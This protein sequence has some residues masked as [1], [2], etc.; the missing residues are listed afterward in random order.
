M[1]EPKRRKFRVYTNKNMD[2]IPQIQRLSESER[3]A[4]QAVSAVLPFRVNDYVIEELINW[5]NIPDDPIFQLTFPQP[6]MLAAEDFSRMTELVG[7]GAA[8]DKIEAAARTIQRR[9]NPHPAGQKELNVPHLGEQAVPGVQHKYRETVLFFP[10]AGQTCHAFCTY[11]FRWAQFVGL[12]DLKFASKESDV[13]VKYL[14]AHP[15]V[16]SVLITGGDPLVMKTKVL[17]RYIEPLLDPKL[18]HIESIRIG[19]KALAYWPF[20]FTTD[21]D[22]DDLMRLFEEIRAAGKHLALMAHYSHPREAETSA[23]QAAIRRVLSTGAVIRCQAPLIRHVNDASEVWSRM[24]R[25]QTR[26]GL[27]PYYMFVERDTG[28]RHY[29]EVPLAQAYKIFNEAY[30]QVSGLSRTVRGPSMST[31]PGKVVIDGIATIQGEK[32][33]LLKFL[34]GRNPKWVGRPFFAKFDDEATWLDDLEPAFGQH[35]FFFESG[36]KRLEDASTRR[37]NLHILPHRDR[38]ASVS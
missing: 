21:E 16:T 13:L 11:C 15:E 10:S 36:M 5:D 19:T 31:S 26:L 17:R 20:R 6:G 3:V 14:K 8:K 33:F 38:S 29:F 34:Q 30:S 2:Q 23:A 1:S 25:L 4:M 32:V 37:S 12:D 35:E 7:T 27:V 22:S 24:W 9:L 18:S 28:A